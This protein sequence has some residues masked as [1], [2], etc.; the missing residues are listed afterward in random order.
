MMRTSI[1]SGNKPPNPKDPESFRRKTFVISSGYRY[2]YIDQPS[3]INGRSD[4]VVLL[5]HG[6]P[7]LAYGWRYQIV[8]LVSRG[9]RT[10]APDLLGYGGTSKPTDVK[11]YSQLKSCNAILEILDHENIKQ[12]VIVV[13]HDWGSALTFRFVQYFP[14]RVK[15]WVTICVPPS[16]P[17]QRGET[18]LDLEKLIRQHLP[19]LGYQLYFM[20]PE[21]SEEINRY[22]KTLILLL[23][24]H[25]GRDLGSP[26]L[27]QFGKL[28][29]LK[30]VHEN[31][32]KD[33][34]REFGNRLEKVEIKD[35][36][37]SYIL[38]E[39]DKG[40]LLGPLSWY[41]TRQI[42]H[43]DE[44]EASL[45]ITFPAELP[46]LH[47]GASN[48]QAFPPSLFTQKSNTKMFPTANLTSY[49]IH[50]GNHFMHQDPLYR[51]QVTQII[52]NWIDSQLKI[53]RSAHP[54]HL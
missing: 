51:D 40:G 31:F 14:E 20:S 24:L 41:K 36:E 37:I 46:C 22:R 23:Y 38:S 39:F 35:P 50:G 33:Q 28:K 19:Q 12:K 53:S 21:F 27:E 34:V 2:S 6:F 29:N 15:C 11:E 13:G 16:R 7:D 10:I 8:D 17:G 42:D 47:L 26:I 25:T 30:Y 1:M 44:Q 52:G 32:L 49:I 3:L 4:D 48:D 43:S 54:S 9:Y 5:L 18:P 45:P